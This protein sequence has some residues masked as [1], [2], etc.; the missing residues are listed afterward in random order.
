MTKLWLSLAGLVLAVPWSR[1]AEEFIAGGPAHRAEAFVE[2]IGLGAALFD[3]EEKNGKKEQK[4]APELFFDLGV[5]YYRAN[6]KCAL[7]PA[8][9]P[10]KMEEW[11]L[12]TGSRPIMLID[13]G[14]N[15]T[16]KLDWLG[17]KKDGDFSSLVAELK[18]YPAV[19]VAGVEAPNE[20]NN[21][22]GQDLNLKYR[23]RTDE[24]AGT[25]Y[26][27]DLY[28]A[29][30]NDPETKNIPVIMYTAIFTDYTLAR[31]TDRMDYLNTHSYQG[32]NVPSS[33]LLMNCTRAMNVLPEG[34]EIKPFIPTEC[35][36]N[37]ELDKTNGMGYTGSLRAQAYGEPM[38]Y[39]EYFR[40][41]I[42]KTL[43]FAL[44]NIDGYG[45]LESDGFTR[46]PS[47]HA[48]QSLIKLLSDAKWNP[49]K[50]Q[51]EG[52]KDFSLRALRFRME[53]APATVHTLT[54]QKENGDWYLLAWNE[55]RNLSA[56]RA[57]VVNPEVP[58]TFVFAPETPV[59]CTG[60]WR[61][62]K[63]PQ[64]VYATPE[65]PLSGAFAPAPLP[66]VKNGKMS[67]GVPSG[68]VIVRLKPQA[69]AT[70]KVAIP[71]LK[72]N[73][74][75]PGRLAITVTMPSQPGFA[76]V[77][78]S[79][80]GMHVAT[81]PRVAF[82]EKDGAL[83]AEW[84]DASAWVRPGLKYPFTAVAVA[85]DGT[86]SQP[87]RTVIKSMSGRCDLVVGGIGV[88]GKADGVIKAGDKVRFAA[89]IANIGVAPTPNPTTG[90]V[91]MYNSSVSVTFAVDG[92]VVG[93]GGN[94]GSRPMSPKEKHRWAAMGGGADGGR[95]IAVP[96]TH[97]VRAQVDDV[98]RISGEENK[99]NNFASRSFTVGDYPGRLEIT[100]AFMA[101][102]VNLSAE[103][104][105]DWMACDQWGGG[106]C[107][108]KRGANLIGPVKQDG[109][110]FIGMNPGCGIS[111]KWGEDGTGA[112]CNDT[113]VGLWGNG[114]GNGYV[115][116]V[117]AGTEERVLRVY[118]GVT[119]GGHGE[120]SVSLSDDSAPAVKDAT[121]NA[122]RSSAWC[123]VP[124]EAPICFTV[125][126]RASK[127]GQKLRVR[128]G[129]V[130]EPNS[131]SA[132]LRLQ[133]MTLSR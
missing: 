72:G 79:R 61:Q 80:L 85:A 34:A 133:G 121:W 91:G 128:W 89:D 75:A 32:D 31:Y 122:N 117:P 96:G 33:S 35:G 99:M 112:P 100:S 4:L 52:G 87:G 48:L 36:Y 60:H 17:V 93:W 62:G 18:R 37:V 10:K 6:L 67:L 39:A 16:L 118:A 77:E 94:D 43:L 27:N 102:Q 1:G 74:P 51:W 84:I 119:N 131:F 101:G 88:D 116:E 58:V 132:Q 109:S 78:L 120:L 123:P 47:W 12:K 90:E 68:V 111:L 107:T 20:L 8:D 106:A 14:W 40:H 28:A 25:L 92:K 57:D 42:A 97:V 65:G 21:K 30:K 104:K 46:R 23:G 126:F 66:E 115:F 11:W 127:P 64:N 45:L 9:Q 53:G 81:L 73:A 41:G 86:Q 69:Q 56:N 55:I 129:L 49:D 13:P 124:D 103:G 83:V 63:I 98:G 70:A 71:Q 19:L 54:L 105:D 5:R 22:F 125:R 3:V 82:K 130:G 29:V 76:A 2:S 44:T 15:R 113:H 38:L 7:T 110:G 59:A 95:W 50:R 24:A 114:K 26:Q 108:R